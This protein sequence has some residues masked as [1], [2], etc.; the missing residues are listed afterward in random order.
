MFL[1]ILLFWLSVAL[2]GY[3]FIGF[4][5]ILMVRGLIFPRPYQ[6]DDSY[7]PSVSMVISAYNEAQTIETKLK[8]ILDLDY[9]AEKIEAIVASDGSDDGT[10]AIVA[11]YEGEIIKSLPLQRV[12]KAAALNA[13]V[14]ASSGDILVF[15][16]ANSLYDKRAIRMLVR[17]LA[18]PQIGGVA[19]DQRYVT[20]VDSTGNTGE[21]G[22]WNFDRLLKELESRGGNVISATG[23]I[24]AIRRSLFM[25]VPE[26]VTDDFATSTRV[27]MQGYRLVFERDAIAYEPVAKSEQR[28]FGRKVRIMT[29]GLTAVVINRALLNPFR[30]GF[31]AIQLFTHKVLR[32]LMYI[33]L[34]IIFLVNPFLLGS[35]I[36][37][38]LTM[39]AQLGFYGAALAGWL[40]QQRGIRIP[41]PMTI[42][43]YACMVY[44]AAIIAS[45]NI[46]RGHRITYWTTARGSRESS[47]TTID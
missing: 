43:M 30:H 9:P 14:E 19:G 18:D 32:R 10:D 2:I 23:A 46:V 27:I 24:Y 11:R 34:I 22:Y 42:P 38:I 5:L 31:Y 6:P 28:E 12:G 3:T 8:N 15:S 26:G 13:A 36:F 21:R 44:I 17:P 35:G 33:P 1:P 41:K 7:T 25:G 4:T 40:A 39:L 45:W 37:Y 16:D 20:S 47:S 29:R